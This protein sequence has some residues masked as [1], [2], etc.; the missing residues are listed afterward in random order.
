M[1]TL[2]QKIVSIIK[3]YMQYVS[4]RP[5]P[6][7]L[8]QQCGIILWQ[9]FFYSIYLMVVNVFKNVGKPLDRIYVVQLAGCKQTV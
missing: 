7:F 3:T 8:T 1:E 5:T 4:P 2:F 9:E 6:S